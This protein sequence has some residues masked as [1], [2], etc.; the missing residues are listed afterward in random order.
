MSC[1]FVNDVELNVHRRCVSSMV[2]M[3][4]LMSTDVV[5][6]R[7]QTSCFFDDDDVGLKLMSSDVVVFLR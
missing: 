2:M 3:W 4:S 5:V 6:L 7:P 1:F